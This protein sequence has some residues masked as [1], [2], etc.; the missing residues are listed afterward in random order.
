MSFDKRLVA[1]GGK[2]FWKEETLIIPE[3]VPLE[4]VKDWSEVVRW[5]KTAREEGRIL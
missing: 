1:C 3:G 5:I 2:E 4:R